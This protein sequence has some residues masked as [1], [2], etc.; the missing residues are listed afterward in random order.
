MANLPRALSVRVGD[1]RG[2]ASSSSSGAIAPANKDREMQIAALLVLDLINPALRENALLELSKVYS[3]HFRGLISCFVY[4]C[5]V[6]CFLLV[7]CGMNLYNFN[8]GL[9]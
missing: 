6:L 8:S 3:F 2:G 9:R 7:A 4:C 5:I 1:S